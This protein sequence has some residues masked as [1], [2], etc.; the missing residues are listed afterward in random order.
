MPPWLEK[1]IKRTLDM[2]IAVLFTW[3]LQWLFQ[4]LLPAPEVTNAL[5]SLA[6]GL[7]V[8]A[9]LRSGQRQ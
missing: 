5:L 2:F 1:L 3:A 4:K 9:V 8:Y 7:A 6:L